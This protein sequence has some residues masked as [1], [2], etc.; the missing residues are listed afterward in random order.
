MKR[1]ANVFTEKK[2]LFPGPSDFYT[3]KFTEKH[4]FFVNFSYGA[5]L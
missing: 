4:L 2:N 3:R 5:P 1:D